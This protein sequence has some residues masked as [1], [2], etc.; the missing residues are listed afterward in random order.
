MKTLTG[1]IATSIATIAIFSACGAASQDDTG[2]TAT[3]ADRP[4]VASPA[5]SRASAVEC[6]R[7]VSPRGS[8]RAAGT[9][10][11]PWRTVQR[12]AV[13][14]RRGD[15]G[16]LRRGTYAG[17]VKLRFAGTRRHP[18]VIRSYPGEAARIVG[19]FWVSR[20]ADWVTV[21]DLYLDG[22]NGDLLPSP[23]INADHVTFNRVD[24]TNWNNGICF[25]LGH[26]R[27]GVARFTRIA[28]SRIHHC[29]RLP[30]TNHD[31]GIYVAHAEAAR[32]HGNWI[33]DNADRGIQFYPSAQHSIVR[34]N[35]IT[36][37]GQGVI[38]SGDG[39][40]TSNGN[41]VERNV[42]A[43]SRL[44]FNVESFFPDEGSVG[45][46]NVL[47]HNC[48]WG[49]ARDVADNGGIQTPAVGFAVLANL[50]VL[51]GFADPARGDFRSTNRLCTRL[52]ARNAKTVPGPARRP[53]P[54]PRNLR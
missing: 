13:G 22:R 10:K 33:H 11:R 3:A 53:P 37:N 9:A 51:P 46:D 17:N 4:P 26:P 44:R 25:I 54:L 12:L 40:L 20:S 36:R 41:L 2:S 6:T 49:G 16:C 43:D 34:A 32:I 50:H 27:Y 21:R 24:A 19:R 29:G 8:D 14:V 7:V 28:N 48:I 18:I 30:A 1:A 31:H 42:I 38:F 35:V 15:V 5:A 23:T 45:D 52:L 39:T 47:R